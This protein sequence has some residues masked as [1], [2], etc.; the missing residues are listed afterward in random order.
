[1]SK[2]RARLNVESLE[3]RLV[4]SQ[5][6]GLP[7]LVAAPA[8]HHPHLFAA[9]ASHHPKAGAVADII[10]VP[11]VPVVPTPTPGP[12]TM[13]WHAIFAKANQLGRQFT[14]PPISGLQAVLN[15]YRIRYANCDI[16]DS[17]ATGAHEVHGAIRDEYNA[18]AHESDCC[19]TAVQKLLSLPTSD[20]MNVPGV[21]GAR[22]NTFQGGAIY[23]SPST[24]AHAVYGAI[25]AL[26]NRL[27]GPTSYLG[28]PTSE[29]QGIPDGQLIPN[30]R[31]S[32]FQGGKILW[33]P[34]GGAHAA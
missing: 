3:S 14:G 27:G 29:E 10:I 20:E 13:A 28:L 5:T 7:A 4:L 30:E 26:Y 12:D 34:Q 17:A 19:G 15:G 2:K 24:G 11:I 31:V 16:Y 21:P 6:P 23:W 32:Y 22:M 8:S 9:P 25:G 18:T 33:T 1:M